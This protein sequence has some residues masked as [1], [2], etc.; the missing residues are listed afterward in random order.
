MRRSESGSTAR[1][2]GR[3]SSDAATDRT[4]QLE[5]QHD[6]LKQGISFRIASEGC[7]ADFGGNRPLK[8]PSREGEA[9]AEPRETS[10]LPTKNGSAGAS[11][12][13]FQRAATVALLLRDRQRDGVRRLCSDRASF[14][15]DVFL[16]ALPLTEREGYL[17]FA[18]PASAFATPVFTQRFGR[19]LSPCPHVS[20]SMIGPGSNHSARS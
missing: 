16:L 8:M 4:Q 1:F 9:P 7:G 11:P 2:V 6:T 19:L 12:A 13:L 14:Q 5:S 20:V 17:E 18:H 15:G 3:N 10:D